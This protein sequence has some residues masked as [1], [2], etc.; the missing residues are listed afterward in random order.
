MPTVVGVPKEI[1][2]QEGRVSMQPD[3]VELVHHDHLVGVESGATKGSG[4]SDEEHERAE[5][6]QLPHISLGRVLG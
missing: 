3:G 5:A 6:H 4:L 2:D 1:K